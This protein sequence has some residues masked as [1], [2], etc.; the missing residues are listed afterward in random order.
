MIDFSNCSTWNNLKERVDKFIKCSTWNIFDIVN[1]KNQ[2]T[3]YIKKLNTL[4]KKEININKLISMIQ[5]TNKTLPY[6]TILLKI[7]FTLKKHLNSNLAH[8]LINIAQQL[9]KQK[10]FSIMNFNSKI[11]NS[12][13]EIQHKNQDS[14]IKILTIHAAK[15]LESK[16]VIFV[17]DILK[18]QKNDILPEEDR[19]ES[20]R[21]I[22]VA[23]TR[24]KDK[25]II[26]ET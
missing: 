13:T 9:S 15:G 20:T 18:K 4:F 16:V 17:N 19:S 2:D 10:K 8:K 22:Y 3:L 26:I 5:K 1:K 12:S 11:Q 6:Y 24:T 25:L 14:G 7:Q 21:L 23:L